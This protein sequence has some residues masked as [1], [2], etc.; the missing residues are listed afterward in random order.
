MTHS[1]TMQAD[2]YW[3][4][5]RSA[6][7]QAA[8][9]LSAGITALVGPSGSGK[10]SLLKALT[11]GGPAVQGTATIKG[12]NILDLPVHKRRLGYA[13]Q[14]SSLFPHMTV[15]DNL[16]FSGNALDADLMHAFEIESLLDRMPAALS[17]GQAKRVAVARAILGKPDILLLDEPTT[18][19]DPLGRMKMMQVLRTFHRVT[20]TPILFTTHLLDDML[21]IAE[22]GILMT[23]N[24]IR[25]TGDIS[26]LLEA[27]ETR[28]ALGITDPGSVVTG[29]LTNMHD[30]LL[31]IDVDG[32]TILVPEKSGK[33][34]IGDT[35]RLRI[36][37]GDIAVSLE[38]PHSTSI[39]NILPVTVSEFDKAGFIGL[40][41]RGTGQHLK[42]RLTEKS[43]QDLGI[44][45]GLPCFAMIKSVAV[46][47]TVI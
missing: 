26:T 20:G 44:A 10:S 42:A 38:H 19:L 47:H 22:H 33:A 12:Q 21:A 25:L 32:V 30:H 6:S 1:D 41:L 29:R 2:F 17:G 35:V 9:T 8:F 3:N 18:G 15:Q 40:E 36:K 4:W 13:P 34:Q 27:Q 24:Q 23:E 7:H 46:W 37:A 14:Q 5:T 39:Q 31:E 28:E 45:E 43:I 11:G 16:E